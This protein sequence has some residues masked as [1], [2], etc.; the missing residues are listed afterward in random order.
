MFWLGGFPALEVT[1]RTPDALCPPLEEARAAIQARVGDVQGAYQVEFGLVRAEDGRQALE[2][3]LR[4]GQEQVLERELPLQGGGCQDAAQAM[5]LVLERYFDAVEKPD[6]PAST[7]EPIPVRPSD[8]SLRPRL[9]VA[10]RERAATPTAPPEQRTCLARLGFLY[11]LELGMAP[12][13][14]LALFPTALRL[15]PS[16]RVGVEL[17]LT[18][19][20][21]PLTQT[22]REQEIRAF[23]LQTALSI[24]VSWRFQPWSVALGPWAQWRAQRA[25]AASLA[26]EQ[27]GYRLL[28]GFGGMLQLAWSP[29]PSWTLGGGIALGAQAAGSASR[30]TLRRAATGPEPVL[31]PESWFGQ[32]QLTVSHEL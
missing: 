25:E 3:V 31:V 19:F 7:L 21:F 17:D 14:G 23:T 4:R 22:I 18:P 5:A 20:V 26:H 24:P 29:N 32:G 16:L 28:A 30:F 9:V 6:Q 1:T 27:P 11:D 15:T 10:P 2:L 13:L 12:T 8:Q